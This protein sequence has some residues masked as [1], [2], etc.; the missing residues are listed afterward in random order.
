VLDGVHHVALV[1]AD[2][3]RLMRF[4]ADAFGGEVEPSD[5]GP[6]FVRLGGVALHVFERGPDDVPPRGRLDHV[7]FRARDADAF[8]AIRIRLDLPDEALRDFGPL[9]SLF[10]ED[11][12]GNLVEVSLDKA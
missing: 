3:E 5:Q 12:D 11:P 2:R 1:T 8:A 4:Y 6:S 9:I 7:S 10:V